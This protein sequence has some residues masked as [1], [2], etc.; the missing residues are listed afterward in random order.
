MNSES[1]GMNVSTIFGRRSLGAQSRLRRGRE[2]GQ[3]LVEY[4][5]LV[6]LVGVFAITVVSIFGSDVEETFNSVSEQMEGLEDVA[7][8]AD[9]SGGWW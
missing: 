8:A 2:L 1:K 6:V 3:G 5:V 4:L 9:S 7:D